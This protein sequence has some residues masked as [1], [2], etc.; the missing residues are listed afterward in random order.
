LESLR[1]ICLNCVISSVWQLIGEQMPVSS[2]LIGVKKFAPEQTGETIMTDF[3]K[4]FLAVAM[5]SGM[6]FGLAA[7]ETAEG[8]GRDMEDAGEAIQEEAD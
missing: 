2:V 1:F 7:C 8:F 3:L 6:G 4:K 5:I